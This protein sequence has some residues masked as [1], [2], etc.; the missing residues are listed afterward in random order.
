MSLQ[1]GRIRILLIS[2]N[3]LDCVESQQCG[4]GAGVVVVATC[5]LYCLGSGLMA[6]LFRV[7]PD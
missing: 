4:D 2:L 1:G 5:F 6:A 3:G 7:H